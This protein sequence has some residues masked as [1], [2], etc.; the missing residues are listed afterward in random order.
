MTVKELADAFN[1]GSGMI[2]KELI[3]RGMMVTINGTIDFQTAVDVASA[4]SVQVQPKAIDASEGVIAAEIE[5]EENLRPRPPI[6]TILGHVD[7]GKTS[8]LDAIRSTRVTEQEHGGITQHIGAYQIEINDRKVTFLDT[9]GHEA[10]TQMRARGASVTDIAVLVVAADDGVQP[11]TIE[12]INHARAANVPLVVAINKVDKPEANLDRVK[13]QLAE[14]G[15]VVNDWGGDVEAVAV[16][17]RRMTGIQDLLETILLVAEIKDLKAN[18]NRPA[19]GTVIEAQLDKT[20]GPIATILIQN[21]TL[22]TGDFVAVG[23]VYGKIRAMENERGKRL[24][25]AEPSSPVVILGLNAVPQAG[26]RVHA[27]PSEQSAR[28]FAEQYAAQ[29]GAEN[30][31]ATRPMTLEEMFK[32]G[33]GVKDLNVVLKAD[34]NG[35][36][37]PIQS[38]LERLGNDEVKVKVI[39]NGTGNVTESDVLLAQASSGIIVGFQVRVEPGAKRAAEAAN[40]DV[41]LYNI[42]YDVVEDVRKALVGMLEP[43]YVDIQEGRAEVRQLFG[44]TQQV[45]GSMVLDGR[46]MR[47]SIARVTRGKDLVGEGRVES[48][49]RFKDDVREVAA[50]YECGI[51]LTGV[52][53]AQIGDIVSTFRKERVAGDIPL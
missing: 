1:V 29:R 16:S 32:Q 41:R 44:K 37:Q 45:L 35:S 46:I 27:A 2:I 5:E 7:H 51:T 31:A 39:H 4:F 14:N 18:P 47:G 15:V 34:V 10:F 12:A 40:V 21:G 30:Q 23:A 19:T 49:R 3:G 50:G 20:R 24:K 17:A 53:N 11:Q 26:D 9:P 28:L 42:I 8:L 33:T 6:V 48:L 22:N 43:K 52:S 25:K 38:S 36:L 13:Q